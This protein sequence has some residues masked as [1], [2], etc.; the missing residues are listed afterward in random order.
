MSISDRHNQNDRR[1]G[2]Y[3]DKF[4]SIG[5]GYNQ[6]LLTVI[7]SSNDVSSLAKYC[8]G[9]LDTLPI[10]KV[11]VPVEKPGAPVPLPLGGRVIAGLELSGRD[12]V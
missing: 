3:D 5:H 9:G 10:T 4:V 2:G 12:E 6:T 1:N 11:S 7:G 8:I